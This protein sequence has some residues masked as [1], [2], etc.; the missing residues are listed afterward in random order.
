M[1]RE[2][3]VAGDWTQFFLCARQCILSVVLS[4][5]I[6]FLCH[7]FSVYDSTCQIAQEIA[8]KIQQRNRNERNGETTTKVRTVGLSTWNDWKLWG[9]KNFDVWCCLL[10]FFVLIWK[11]HWEFWDLRLELQLNGRIFARLL[12]NKMK[13]NK[14]K[15]TKHIKVIIFWGYYNWFFIYFKGNSFI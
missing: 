12:Q 8:E 3:C 13:V 4:L 2:I 9:L 15:E 14:P 7:R 11:S 1:L 10:A 6:F 5:N